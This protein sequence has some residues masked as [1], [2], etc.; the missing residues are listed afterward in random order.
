[1]PD[2]HLASTDPA[3]LQNSAQ[4]AGEVRRALDRLRRGAALLLADPRGRIAV[5]AV[6]TLTEATLATLRDASDGPLRLAMTRFRAGALGLEAEDETVLATL[7]AGATL[8]D[9]VGIAEPEARVVSSK[10]TTGAAPTEDRQVVAALA[11]AKVA[12]LMPM[13]LVADGR[14]GRLDLPALAV[15]DAESFAESSARWLTQVADARVPLA[16]AENARLIAFRP[17]GGGPEHLAIVIGT[18]DVSTPV[19][20]RIHSSCF[21]GD[22]LG[23]LR[24]DCGDQLRGAIRAIAADG[25]GVVVYLPQEGRGIGLVNKLR[26]YAL[27]DAGLDTID[28]N[29]HLGFAPDERSY[30]AAGEI[31]RRLGITRIRLLTNNPGKGAALAGLGVDVV[32]RV[33]LAFPA[34]PHNAAYL[35]TKAVRDGH[36][37]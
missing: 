33:Q 16:E 21:T 26:A 25:A 30:A 22:L 28:A 19:L 31:L 23:S 20:V 4:R 15:E 12:G 37:F 27:Q 1:M 5:A 34:N 14:A 7:D 3:A 6:E 8:A 18:P 35:R 32:E 10:L 9:I 2:K 24:C 29:T 11:L 17:W 36:N 13:V